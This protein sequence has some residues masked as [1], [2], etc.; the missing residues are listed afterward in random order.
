MTKLHPIAL[1][2]QTRSVVYAALTTLALTPAAYGQVYPIAET[3]AQLATPA[4]QS[5]GI[6]VSKIGTGYYRGSGAVARHGQLIYSCGHMIASNGVW[7]SE[8]YFLRAWNS[9]TLPALSQ[10]KSVRGYKKYAEYQGPSGNLQFSQDF[11]VGYDATNSFGTPLQTY[12]DGAKLLT[13]TGTTKLIAGY[14]A[15]IDFT[16]KTGGAFQYY[17]GTFTAA[18]YSVYPT[19]LN[20]SGV[21]T[22][23]GNSGGPVFV[24]DNGTFKIAGVLIS[25]ATN[26]AGVYALS[27]VAET[28]ALSAMSAIGVTASPAPTPSPK[29]TPTPAPAPKPTPAPAPTGPAGVTITC[30]GN[31]PIPDGNSTY[32]RLNLNVTGLTSTVK[33]VTLSL[34]IT[35]KVAGNLDVYLQSPNGRVSYIRQ[36]NTK[37]KTA[38]VV[39]T[40]AS[41]TSTFAGSTCSGTWGLFMRDV[42]K[43]NPAT[44]KS[45]VLT[46][47]KL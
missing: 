8:L 40:N 27:S 33:T 21:S 16:G 34:N 5:T 22:G 39:L 46:I 47:A 38:D 25:G 41:L 42:V 44:F 3:A 23:G 43:G 26:A 10:M 36:N 11:I 12:V 37:D 30:N 18:M 14:P 15:K 29:P 24:S 20:I 13:T 1:R 6:V 17:T 35:A 28:M 31:L 32:T 2:I 45:S 4:S 7:A 9:S 19:Y